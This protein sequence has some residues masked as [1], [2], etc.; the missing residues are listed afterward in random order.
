MAEVTLNK[1]N[2]PQNPDLLVLHSN[3]VQNQVTAL[4]NNR[5]A[6]HVLKDQCFDTL[7]FVN[8]NDTLRSV[9]FFLVLRFYRSTTKVWLPQLLLVQVPN[10][11]PHQYSELLCN[12]VRY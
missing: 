12:I 11:C 5:L 2:F 4:R 10:E 9:N 3:F 1:G 6:W 8:S 7:F